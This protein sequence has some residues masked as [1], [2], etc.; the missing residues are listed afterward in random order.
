MIQTNVRVNKRSGAKF[1]IA[2][3]IFDE[4]IRSKNRNG[5]NFD[6]EPNATISPSG[7]A[8]I[9]VT[10]NIMQF[11]PNPSVKDRITTSKVDIS[12]IPPL[13]IP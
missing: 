1:A 7:I 13:I 11:M 8:V 9:S 4:L 12:Y 2:F 3:K 10:A 5:L 6:I